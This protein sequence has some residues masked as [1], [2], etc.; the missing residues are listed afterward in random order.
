MRER[1]RATAAARGRRLCVAGRAARRPARVEQ[2]LSRDGGGFSAAGDLH[3]VIRQVEVFGFHFA[4]LDIRQHVKVHRAA[5]HEI[6]E[7]AGLA[8]GYALLPEEERAALLATH[9]ADRRPLI[10]ADISRFTGPTR[11]RLRPSG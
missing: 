6:F 8:P 3:D 1:L 7:R 2:A 9:I 5:L 10:P 11:R 4:T